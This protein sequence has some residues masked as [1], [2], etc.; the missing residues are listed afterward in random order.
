MNKKYFLV[1]DSLFTRN[2]LWFPKMHQFY[3]TL[4][5]AIVFNVSS[6]KAQLPPANA[7]S[8][9]KVALA[10]RLENTTTF[11]FA[12]DGRI[13]LLDRY[14]KLLVY[15]ESDGFVKSAGNIPVFHELED[16]LLGLA[17]DPNFATNNIIYIFY[18]PLSSEFVGNRV[19][20]F[21]L[22]GD[23][24]DLSSEKVL[25][26]WETSRTAL[27][28][29][30]GD[31]DFDSQG[32][33]YIATG[34]NTTYPDKYTAVS[35]DV[36]VASAE[37]TSANTMDLR[38]KILR[39]TPDAD[40]GYVVPQGNLFSNPSQG[41]PEIYVMGVR[42]PY[43]LFVDKSNTDWLFWGEVGPDAAQAST[44]GPEGLDE[45]NLAKSPGNYGWPYFS[46]KD[47]DPYQ[48]SYDGVPPFYNDPTNPVN[49]SR[50]NTGATTLPPAQPAWLEIFHR[51]HLPGFRYYYDSSATDLQRLPEE[52]D[53]ALFYY[54]FNASL[55]F[56]ITMDTNGNIVSNNIFARSAFPAS[57][58]GF[59]DMELGPDGKMYILAYGVSCC[60]SN[61]GATGT[62]YRVDYTGITQNSPPVV[63]LEAT[64][65]NGN[66]PLTVQFSSAGTT[67][68]NGDSPLTYEWDFGDGTPVS[69]DPN[70]MH[71]YTTQ[72]TFNAQ[73]KV[74]DGNT[75]NGL[76]I[77]N[78]LIYAGNTTTEFTV[79][80]PVDGGLFNWGDQVN[81]NII[82]QD[83]EDGTI[84]CSNISA[85]P[86][87]GHINHVHPE[88]S[89]TG[90]NDVYQLGGDG[91]HGTDGGDDIYA[92]IGI[93]FTDSGGL[94]ARDLITL[95]PKRKEAEFFDE[96]QGTTLIA[97][98]N[99]VEGGAS[100][101]RVDAG[102]HM[103]FYN[104]NLLNI[105][106]VKY[107]VAATNAGGSIEM[108]LGSTTGTLVAT[109][110]VPATGGPNSWVN[111]E[112]N[113]TAP[114]GK[115]NLFFVF[116][117]SGSN[118]FDLNY[119]EFKGDGVSTD[120]S[121]PLVDDV[122]ASSETT[123]EVKFSEYVTKA[124]AENLN[125]YAIDKGVTISSAVLQP[126]NQIVVLT[127]SSLSAGISYNL[128]I[129]N[130]QNEANLP[131]V[132]TT[133]TF[134]TFNGLRINSGGPSVNW[135]GNSFNADQFSSGGDDFTA[136]IPIEGTTDDAL[137]QSERFA[138]TN[139]SL[140]YEIPVGVDGEYDIRLHFAEIRFGVA[141][142]SGGIGSRVFNVLIEGNQVLSNFDIFGEVGPA[143]ALQKEFNNVRV[144][145][146]FATITLSKI[147]G[148][149]KISGLE[150]L[151]PDSFD[152]ALDA[153]ITITSPS[154]G[155]DVNEPFDVAFRV[156]NWTILEGDTHVHYFI[157]DMMI[158]PY[159]SYEPIRFD[160][161][162]A[163]SHVI[164]IELFQ[165]NHMGTGIFDEVT[166]NVTGEISCN[167]TPFPDDWGVKQLETTALP[168]RSIYTFAD[169]DL[170][171]DG[172]KDIVTGGWWYK[173]PGSV[174]G[175][176]QRSAIGQFFDNVAHVYDFDDDG[177]LDLLGVTSDNQS[178][179]DYTGSTLVWASNDGS[180]NF[181]IFQNIANRQGGNAA[182]DR[183]PFLA[184]IAGGVFTP[185]G[186]YQMAI[187]WNAAEDFNPRPKIQLLTP[188][189]N[190]ESGTWTLEDM[191]GTISSG[192]DLQVGDIDQDND[193]DLFQGENWIRNNN[194]TWSTH[195]TGIEYATIVDRS[196]L[197]DF[198]RDGR[199][200]AVVGQ[201]SLPSSA[202]GAT[203]FAW[204]K[205][206]ANLDTNP[207]QDWEKNV[208]D[209]NINGSLSVFATDIDFDGDKDIVVGEWRGAHRLVA[210]E[211]NLC[212][213]GEFTKHI[214]DGGGSATSFA[215][216]DGAR[217][218]D[219]DNDG[220]LDVISNGWSTNFPRIYENQTALV[221]DDRP[222]V[223][224]GINQ[225]IIEGNAT[226]TGTANDPDG[227]NIVSYLWTKESGGTAT[228]SG[229]T[230]PTLTLSNL[231]AGVYVFRLTVVDDEGESGFD[232]VTISVRSGAGA[233]RINAG[234]PSFTFNSINWIADQYSNMGEVSENDI[235][236]ANTANDQLYQTERFHTG[237]LVYEIPVAN[238]NHNVNLHFAE[239]FFG[240][241]G[242]GETGGVGS[243]IF[244][245]D[246]EDGEGALSNYDIVAQA[247][248]SATAVVANFTNVSVDDGFLTITFTGVTNNSKISGI[249][250]IPVDTDTAL[251]VYAGDDATVNLPLSEYTLDGSAIDPDGSAITSV[252]WTQTGGSSI[253]NF[254]STSDL[255]PTISNL[256]EGQYTF[257]LTVT[258]DDNET[259]SDEVIISVLSG[260]FINSGGPSYNDGGINWSMDQNFDGGDTFRNP[261]PIAN[262]TNDVLFQTERFS[263][264]GTLTYEIPVENGT[265]SVDLFFAE[266]Y[267]GVPVR[268]TQ[269][270]VGSRIFNVDIENGQE[271]LNNYDIFEEAG[272]SATAVIESFNEIE[273]TDG[274]LTIILTGVVAE[275]KISGIGVY[276]LSQP[277]VNAGDDQTIMLPDSDAILV[278]T[279]SDPDGG[280][281]TY[282][283]T[284][285]SGPNTATLENAAT[286]NLT[287]TGLIA[288]TYVFRLTVTDD[289]SLVSF[290]E[291]II[292]VTDSGTSTGPT[293]VVTWSQV[294]G[295]TTVNFVG[296]NSTGV[297]SYLWNFG[298]GR[299]STE[300]DP[301]HT[302]LE[303]GTYTVTLR[304]TDEG[305]LTNTQEIEVVVQGATVSE[306]MT[307]TLEVNPATSGDAKVLVSNLPEGVSVVNITLHD[308]GGRYISGHVPADVKLGNTYTIPVINLRDGLYFIRVI[309]SQG[310]SRLIKLYVKN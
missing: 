179:V 43:R 177:D 303:P 116:K 110:P 180:G 161:L 17:F 167:D 15:K 287:V 250:V 9:V 114:S 281:L 156:D 164:K 235:A 30:G 162:G 7:N 260:L 214:L 8:F 46:G 200:D 35:E 304:V 240:V 83:A 305:G 67:D 278:G 273:V 197:A 292:E 262:T 32:N 239:I 99:R 50:W 144:R 301:S 96:Q 216:H 113:F 182:N 123:I 21:T 264:T 289:E 172:L 297:A 14:G 171:G 185:G 191:N 49:Q 10:D 18:S 296:S 88:I 194:G 78:I 112:T 157:D 4:F 208:L 22:N 199:L 128:T 189:D 137:Y 47:N 80:S 222:V 173:N 286:A 272:G 248:G 306:Q 265:Y 280:D 101:L 91:S 242:F 206:P 103:A 226:L 100:A 207:D 55:L 37:R 228:L 285:Q 150:V 31:M 95:H 219:I 203:E 38:G 68:P 26:Q 210:F 160:N 118:I 218:T 92:S 90:C 57:Q 62:L 65:T 33:L 233:I 102:G 302:Y 71:V 115:N 148:N 77:K 166:V 27:Y 211:N 234:G 151:P 109:T 163:G 279:A 131:V 98:T 247:G 23:D 294:E 24:L 107:Q 56:Y 136:T 252:L 40:G 76:S 249:E 227:G 82:G 135:S 121:P 111:V 290:D 120:L 268:G 105:N 138:P 178:P 130:V 300:A 267:Y 310:D 254:S 61:T 125:N 236:I 232:E 86:G 69:T 293:A 308:V 255:D 170:D 253:V 238:G 291:V 79:N 201:L 190:P 94:V 139:N 6:L 25:L 241:P 230:T 66:L 73:V 288:G 2:F 195:D 70:P 84:D 193:L 256:V 53:G 93:R 132:T 141:G 74:S 196:Q 295:G 36:E 124:T 145:D 129:Q 309:I 28:H 122:L 106:A 212:S 259:V 299:T 198:N 146:G 176:W 54:D 134:T 158:G 52:L 181:T 258:N 174:A 45:L 155:W 213:T 246:I 217:V 42:N 44:K 81:I 154:N 209:T 187:N 307:M 1:L 251:Q 152:A 64:P 29:S 283:W 127:T 13:F 89:L 274:A 126:N 245:V 225:N 298:D 51:C 34:D 263:D 282:Q 72:G 220:D 244:N 58:E 186:K 224:A 11:K 12:P 204:F 231:V 271:N 284:Q 275:P 39:I 221:A 169:Y 276:A 183:E 97:N 104:R 184:G 223:D 202:T 205:A 87:L 192:E 229:E 142:Q 215:H 60:D 277:I 108:R 19:S 59:I 165:A 48:I 237:T 16:G 159:Y 257:R 20:Q 117:G 243:R 261:I 5:V 75:D 3:I 270:G 188:S 41:R 140:T 168:Y 85:T 147:T 149:P 63:Q 133:E 153:S 175:V 119:I 269:G 143:T 266:I